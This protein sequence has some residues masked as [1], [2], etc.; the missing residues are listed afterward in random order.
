MGRAELATNEPVLLRRAAVG[1]S[2]LL[3]IFGLSNGGIDRPSPRIDAL[4]GRLE[5]SLD[6]QG[7][8]EDLL[9]G[10][11]DET[12]TVD[13]P[14][15]V[16]FGAQALFMRHPIYGTRCSTVIIV[17]NE[18]RGR[19]IERSFDPEGRQIGEVALTFRWT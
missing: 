6:E 18:G 2:G 10:L 8:E 14:A 19:M 17:D 13:N 3:G 1:P 7:D 11:R 5:A 15:E 4:T 9:E 16:P 12:P